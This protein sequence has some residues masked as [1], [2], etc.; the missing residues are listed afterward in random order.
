MPNISRAYYMSAPAI[1]VHPEIAKSA[2][3]VP[4]ISSRLVLHLR[5]HTIHIIHASLAQASYCST[6]LLSA[7]GTQRG[8][9]I[10]TSSQVLSFS[11][12]SA[13][14]VPRPTYTLSSPT[15]WTEVLG[16]VL[17]LTDPRA[18][19]YCSRTG[20]RRTPSPLHAY[21][22]VGWISLTEFYSVKQSD[23]SRKCV[24]FCSKAFFYGVD[25][26]PRFCF[27]RLLL[28]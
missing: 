4:S 24:F 1:N 22:Q 8:S 11:P 25:T 23:A 2:L 28:L 5:T 10:S 13:V 27:L 20:H 18:K 21:V 3:L 6:N 17:G 14:R 19:T 12:T 26:T 9:L 15:R 16:R 7:G